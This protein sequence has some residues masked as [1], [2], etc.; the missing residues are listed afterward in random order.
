MRAS[1]IKKEESGVEELEPHLAR[2]GDLGQLVDP[3]VDRV[4]RGGELPA[5][6]RIGTAFS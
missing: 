2:R 1:K 4:E 3:R 5:H 6:L